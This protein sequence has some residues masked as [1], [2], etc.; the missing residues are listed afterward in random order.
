MVWV[1]PEEHK[2]VGAVLAGLRASANLKQEE[3]AVLLQKPQSFI[4]SYE[5]GQR[6]ID[7]LEFVRIV[8]ALGANPLNAFRQV[9]QKRFIPR[10]KPRK[11]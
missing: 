10:A 5:R 8:T 3:L 11:R 7:L 1:K 9:V 4:S 6:R 2:A